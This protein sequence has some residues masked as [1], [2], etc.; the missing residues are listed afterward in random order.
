VNSKKL[1]I[2]LVIFSTLIMCFVDGVITPPYLI[3]S[4]IK[5]ALFLVIPMIYFIFNKE[6]HSYLNMSLVR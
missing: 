5:I 2:V 3:K 1:V 4:I 6:K